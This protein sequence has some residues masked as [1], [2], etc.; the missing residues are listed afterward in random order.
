M[1]FL[2]TNKLSYIVDII[3]DIVILLNNSLSYDFLTAKDYRNSNQK[4]NKSFYASFLSI[5]PLIQEYSAFD[6][7]VNTIFKWFLS[8]LN[9]FA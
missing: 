9:M 4:Y 3:V 6:G 7:F 1:F 5:I 8:Y 2:K